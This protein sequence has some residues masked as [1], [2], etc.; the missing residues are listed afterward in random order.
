M[1]YLLEISDFII[2]KQ[3]VTGPLQSIE[4]KNAWRHPL[5][6]NG[7]VFGWEIF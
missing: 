4:F 2:Q 3:E 7:V 5:G 6:G 1:N